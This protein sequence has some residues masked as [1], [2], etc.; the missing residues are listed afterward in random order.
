MAEFK[1]ALIGECMAEISGAPFTAMQQSFGGDSVNTAVYLKSLLPNTGQASFVTA[2]G[3]DQLSQAII[4]KWQAY[5]IDTQYVLIDPN[6]HVGLYHIHNDS[7]GERFF[8]YWRND[9]AARFMM[10]HEQIAAVFDNLQNY[11]AVFL[12]GISLAVLPEDDKTKLVQ[13]LHTLRSQGTKIIF[14][15]N[16]RP[17]LWRDIEETKHYYDKIYALSDLALV[18]FE[19]EQIIWQDSSVEACKQRLA[20]YDINEIVIKDGENG[21]FYSTSALELHVPTEVVTNVVDTTSAGDS[22]NAGFLAAW[23]N[24]KTP[25]QC[26]KVANKLASKV[27]QQKGAIVSINTDEVWA[28]L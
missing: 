11:D 1:L 10:Q 5:G 24:D 3:K 12:S 17:A 27:I 20:K 14:D 2:M 26:C 25:E 19:D 28:V 9:S 21:C 22:F 8:Q 4:E 23:L 7:S 15:S 6:K 18:T 13:A 16:Y